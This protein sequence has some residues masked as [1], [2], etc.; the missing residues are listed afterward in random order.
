MLHWSFLEFDRS[1][2]NEMGSLGILG[3]TIK[4]LGVWLRCICQG[5][6]TLVVFLQQGMD[7]QES[8]QWPMVS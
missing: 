2:M 7:V 6:M 4:G 3:P 5:D 1:I 8:L